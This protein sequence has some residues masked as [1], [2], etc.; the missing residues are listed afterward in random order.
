MII[1]A[2]TTTSVIEGQRA[3]FLV[4]SEDIPASRDMSIN[5]SVTETGDFIKNSAPIRYTLEEGEN[6]EDLYIETT[7]DNLVEADGQITVRIL[8]GTNYWVAPATNR[9]A[10]IVIED[11]DQIAE[12]P[13]LDL[14]ASKTSVVEGDS[15]EF[16]IGIENDVR[17]TSTLTININI[18]RIGIFFTRTPPPTTQT[19][20]VGEDFKSI[21]INT[22]E[23]SRYEPQGSAQLTILPGAGYNISETTGNSVTV[24]ITD[25]KSPTLPIII[26]Q[27]SATFTEGSS[28]TANGA[29]SGPKPIKLFFYADEVTPSSSLTVSISVSTQ[30]SFNIF[31]M[32][33]NRMQSTLPTS[34]T[35]AKDED[36]VVKELF[37]EDDDWYQEVGSITVTIKTW[38]TGYIVANKPHNPANSRQFILMRLLPT[39]SVIWCPKY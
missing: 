34:V 25:K 5:I 26:A 20:L 7:D 37:V 11:N 14:G 21:P 22:V 17:H 27:S 3:H 1:V 9:I 33:N 2:A 4:G 10:S 15:F 6:L 38:F 13:I 29:D 19:M 24:H 28:I 36:L 8:A 12:L 16:L 35:F 23:N 31:Q 32:I 18:E 30:G 39:I